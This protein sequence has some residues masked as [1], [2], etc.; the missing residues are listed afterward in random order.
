LEITVERADLNGHEKTD[1]QRQGDQDLEDQVQGLYP[2][3]F[4]V[5]PFALNPGGG[6]DGGAHMEKD[7]LKLAV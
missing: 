7:L 4:F 3:F 5:P 6:G 2:L 1:R